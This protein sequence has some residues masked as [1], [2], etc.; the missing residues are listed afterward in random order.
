MRLQDIPKQTI[1]S[2]TN[3]IR[4]LSVDQVEAA[5]SGHPGLPLGAAD[6]AFVLFTEF[7]RYN[8]KDPKWQGRDR[9][10]LSAGHG[11]ALLYS[12]LHLAGFDLPIDELKRFRQWGSKTPGH[13]EFGHTI[14]VE[15]TTG[16]LGQGFANAVGMAIAAKILNA[17]FAQYGFEPFQYKVYALV[18]DGDLMEGISSEAGSIAGHL[19][20]DNL[21]YIYDSNRISIEGSTDLAFT[22]RVGD[23]FRSFGFEVIE[24]DGHNHTEI[25]TALKVAQNAQRPVMIIAHTHI[26]FGSPNKQGSADSHGSPLGA[27]EVELTRKALGWE[28]PPFTVP[29]EVYSLFEAR[30]AENIQSANEWKQRF[31]QMLK[32]NPEADKLW[33]S[34]SGRELPQ[35]LEERLLKS[36]EGIAKTATRSAS[37]KVMQEIA[38]IVPTFVGGSADLAPSTKTLISGSGDI[39]EGR[40]DGRNMHFGVREHAMGAIINGM[41]V[42]GLFYPFCST[43]LVFSDYMKMTVRLAALMDIPSIF[44]FTHD[45]YWVG[46]DGPTHQPIEHAATLR[47]IPNSYTFRPADA[48]ETALCWAIALRKSCSPSALLLTRQDVATLDKSVY[49]ELHCARG[50]YLLESAAKRDVTLIASGSEVSIALEAARLLYARGVSAAV[51]SMPCYELFFEQERKYREGVLGS[52]PRVVIEAGSSFGLHRIAPEGL[53]ITRDAF[54]ASAPGEEL[55]IRFGFAP[56]DVAEKV[57]QWLTSNR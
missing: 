45:S 40:F 39:Q 50:A 21:I 20:L 4:F 44:V 2:A 52:A 15:T 22:E 54:A 28:H 55:A 46:E 17:K 10:V 53:F 1:K 11:S 18:S 3:A 13:P 56:A 30:K 35:D 33:R 57:A 9:F 38:K 24:I 25:S 34:I 29:Q 8:P 23:R 6:L 47:S 14:G 26:G 48:R 16:P 49:P 32:S 7:L 42:S 12:L 19:K 41:A 36:V 5:K 31:E 43:F 51:V 27:K 37:G